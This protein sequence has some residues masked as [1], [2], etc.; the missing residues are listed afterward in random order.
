MF[1]QNLHPDLSDAE[2]IHQQMRMAVLAEEL[3]Y[4]FVLFPEHHFESYSMMCDNIQ[5]LTWVAARTNRIK[6]FV[7]VSVLPWNDPLRVA[8][9][10]LLLDNLSG[11]RVLPGFGRGL[12]A[13]EYKAFRVDQGE[14]RE[15]FGEAIA[16]VS[17]ALETGVMEGAGPFYR[18][19][20]VELRP[21]PVR[22]FSDRLWVAA[23]SPGTVDHVVNTK[24]RLMNPSAQPLEAYVKLFSAYRDA[25]VAA[26]HEEPLPPLFADFGYCHEDPEVAESVFRRYV[27]PAWH[28]ERDH[29]GLA[30]DALAKNPPKGY[31]Q[32]KATALAAQSRTDEENVDL[33]WEMMATGTPERIIE[34][35]T[36]RIDT[37]GTDVDVLFVPA[38][39]GMPYD[40]V[41]Q[42]MRLHAA[43]VMPALREL[44]R[45]KVA[46]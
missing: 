37:V 8:E 25:F 19:P 43:E 28:A 26:H 14:A 29:Y 41:E 46:A 35:L 23:G 33:K 1:F 24:A 12:A 45:R 27:L 9:K 32:Y 4:D 39:G 6:L 10:I 30:T 7:G 22:T 3:G 40:K 18:Q 34:Q 17:E 16:M 44:T 15:R 2:M 13:M 42:S 31:E 38:F 11:G 21:R 20:R 5:G 36:R